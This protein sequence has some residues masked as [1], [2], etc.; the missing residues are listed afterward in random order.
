M[1]ARHAEVQDGLINV[2]GGGW[3][4]LTVTD[5]PGGEHAGVGT[6]NTS[7]VI[8]LLLD[9]SEVGASHDLRVV[10]VGV[11]GA[12]LGDFG[13]DIDAAGAVDALGWEQNVS[14]ALQLAA[15][16]LPAL[17][18]YTVRLEVDGA[19]LGERQFRVQPQPAR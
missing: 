3:D 1:L 19:V 13:G 12:E 16:P 10:I 2:L 5:R 14:V 17:G 18:P 9:P 4:T 11:D 7:V 8:R 15:L 6:L